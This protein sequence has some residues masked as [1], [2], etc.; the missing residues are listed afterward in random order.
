MARPKTINEPVEEEKR[1]QAEAEIMPH[2]STEASA[3]EAA[4]NVDEQAEIE[5]S[6]EEG[7]DLDQTIPAEVSAI[8]VGNESATSLDKEGSEHEKTKLER[9]KEAK[10][11]RLAA[12]SEKI[13]A[14]KEEHEAK[15]RHSKKFLVAKAKVEP[16]KLYQMAEALT[17]IKELSVSKFDGSVEIHLRLNKK[18]AKGSTE[19]SRGVVH[20]PHGTG[21]DKKVVVLDEKTIDQIAKTKKLDFDICIASPELMPQV[22][23]IAKILGPKGKMPDPKSGTVTN[24]PKKVMEEIKSGKTEY[25]VDASGIVHQ[26]IGKVSWEDTKLAENAKVVMAIYPKSRLNSVFITA[27]IA[28]SIPLDL[29]K[30]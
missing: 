4:G 19:S 13:A 10:A 24:D 18:K 11:E 26:I 21:K 8:H 23:K 6:V 2:H 28:P 1:A 5:T 20:M 9:K 15:S 29:S 7:A 27:S 16:G 30:L 3:D 14:S 22:A 25:R 17:L 12:K